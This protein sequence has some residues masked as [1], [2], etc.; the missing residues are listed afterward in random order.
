MPVSV[1]KRRARMNAK[2]RRKYRNRKYRISNMPITAPYRLFRKLRYNNDFTDLT[3]SSALAVGHVYRLNGLYDPDV[4]GAGNQPR[5]FDQYMTMYNKYVVLGA[6][7]NVKFLNES[8]S[9]HTRCCIRPSST[10]AIDTDPV[11]N[12]EARDSKSCIVGPY[13][14]GGTIKSLTLK[15]SAKKWFGKKSVLEERDLSGTDVANPSTQAYVIVLNDG[16]GSASSGCKCQVTI[17]Y[18]VCFQEPL[19]PNQS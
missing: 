11:D 7:V 19:Q 17:D 16:L 15:W 18:L 4:T 2:L 14:G 8:S 12:L 9:T 6:L 13:V 10:S 5:G 1:A 3:P